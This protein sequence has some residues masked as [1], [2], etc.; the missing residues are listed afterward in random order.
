MQF[1]TPVDT[2][3][4]DVLSQTDKSRSPAVT[5]SNV[6]TIYTGTLCTDLADHPFLLATPCLISFLIFLSRPLS[7]L[8]LSRFSESRGP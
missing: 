2:M 8:Y 1:S 5:W 4:V 6:I 3:S 7:G